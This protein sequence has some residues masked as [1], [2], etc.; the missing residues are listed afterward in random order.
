MGRDNWVW[1]TSHTLA[2]L[3]SSGE[4]GEGPDAWCVNQQVCVRVVPPATVAV[5]D[6]ADADV[7]VVLRCLCCC[8]RFHL[9]LQL[10][11]DSARRNTR[12][13]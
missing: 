12:S 7:L 8:R 13:D 6:D 1:D 5:V 10:I 4:L 11:L 2:R 9:T 3:D